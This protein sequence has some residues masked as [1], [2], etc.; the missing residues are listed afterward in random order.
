VR[1]IPSR[2][3]PTRLPLASSLRSSPAAI[4]TPFT[5]SQPLPPRHLQPRC[6]RLSEP[7]PPIYDPL[8]RI[9][10]NLRFNRTLSRCWYTYGP[11][12]CSQFSMPRSRPC[13]KQRALKRQQDQQ[14]L[15]R[16]HDQLQSD[17]TDLPGK[18]HSDSVKDSRIEKQPSERQFSTTEVDAIAQVAVTAAVTA[19]VNVAKSLC[20]T[21]PSHDAC[22]HERRPATM[23]AGTSGASLSLRGSLVL[24][25]RD[26]Q[27]V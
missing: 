5:S 14:A 12:E 2:D 17:R 16:L 22:R 20:Y 11:T 21:E 26:G 27:T 4:Y 6:H 18:P 23:P 19:T 10:K 7:S 15:N 24:E 25:A 8:R 1:T 3:S 9:G 13:K